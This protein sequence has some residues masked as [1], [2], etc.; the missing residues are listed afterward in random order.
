MSERVNQANRN[1]RQVL[2][3]RALALVACWWLLPAETIST[4]EHPADGPGVTGDTRGPVLRVNVVD[5]AS[6]HPIPNAMIRVTFPLATD[7]PRAGTTTDESGVGTLSMPR[8]TSTHVSV[9]AEGY[10]WAEAAWDAATWPEETSLALEPA[11]HIGG[12]VVNQRGTPVRG[13]HIRLIR[14]AEIIPGFG[15]FYLGHSEYTDDEGRWESLH[16]PTRL[17]GLLIQVFHPDHAVATFALGSGGAPATGMLV[18]NQLEARSAVILLRLG[19]TVTGKVVDEAGHA[20]EGAR[21]SG[22]SYPAWS[23]GTG[24]FRLP[25]PLPARWSSWWRRRD[26][27]R[28]SGKSRYP[29]ASRNR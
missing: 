14:G 10:A 11:S 8:L 1:A 15:E 12:I 21:I 27:R 7:L 28:H 2:Q 9:I 20:V 18:R 5:A 29:M 24:E 26:S 16:A 19:I 25:N 13:A 3:G 17:E 4:A 22:G 6:R 23:S